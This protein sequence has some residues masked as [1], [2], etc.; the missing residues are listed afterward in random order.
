MGGGELTM[1][2]DT[3]NTT[4]R[5]QDLTRKLDHPLLVSADFVADWPD[6]PGFT[7][8]GPQKVKGR[9]EPIQVHHP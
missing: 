2:G 4:F 5:L 7:A 9:K 1:L 3:V 8:L 6:A